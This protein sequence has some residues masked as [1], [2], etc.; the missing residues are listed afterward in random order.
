MCQSNVKEK[1]VICFHIQPD[2][3]YLTQEHRC[4]NMSQS[5]SSLCSDNPYDTAD[6]W[7]L[8]ENLPLSYREQVVAFILQNTGQKDFTLDPTFRDPYTGGQCAV[9]VIHLNFELDRNMFAFHL[10][11]YLIILFYFRFPRSSQ[12]L[13]ARTIFKQVWFCKTYFQTYSEGRLL[14]SYSKAFNSSLRFPCVLSLSKLSKHYL[15]LHAQYLSPRKPLSFHNFITMALDHQQFL[16]QDYS[17]NH[18]I[19][20]K[21]GWFS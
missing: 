1:Q 8:K 11:M 18:V 9:A 20:N 7:L 14:I 10:I 3:L 4:E 12:C 13:C 6:K 16:Y 15:F 19:E 17:L 21:T 5:F 2:G